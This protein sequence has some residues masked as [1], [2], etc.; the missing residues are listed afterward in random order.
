M[1]LKQRAGTPLTAVQFAA[2]LV[3]VCTPF[4][5]FIMDAHSDSEVMKAKVVFMEAEITA[6]SS[7]LREARKEN[8]EILKFLRDDAK[9][10]R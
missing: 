6:L 10:P 9:R 5:A 7:D 4:F 8:Q 2:A 1:T 3:V